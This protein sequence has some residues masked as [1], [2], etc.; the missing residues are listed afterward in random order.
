M[1]GLAARMVEGKGVEEISEEF[2]IPERTVTR[3]LT[4]VQRGPVGRY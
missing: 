3:W 2:G 1:K 4:G